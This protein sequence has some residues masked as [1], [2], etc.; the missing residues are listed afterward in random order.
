[1]TTQISPEERERRQQA[2][3]FHRSNL[4]LENISVPPELAD[5][6]DRYVAGLLSELEY[7]GE[8][9][10]YIRLLANNPGWTP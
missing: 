1:M 5:I 10:R 7:Q 2:V 6:Q 3:N 9:I 8:C 4:R